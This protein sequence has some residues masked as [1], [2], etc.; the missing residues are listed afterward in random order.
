MATDPLNETAGAWE[1][2]DGGDGILLLTIPDQTPEESS[3]SVWEDGHCIVDC[4]IL[5]SDDPWLE[6]DIGS[7]WYLL[8]R[9]LS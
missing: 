8:S 3:K 1:G 4:I 5:A 2:D 9:M 6:L 7:V